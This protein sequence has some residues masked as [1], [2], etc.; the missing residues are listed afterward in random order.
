MNY[1][2]SH[3]TLYEFVC[4]SW[5]M[6][7]CFLG[8][9]HLMVSFTLIFFILRSPHIL[10]S[11]LEE[12]ILIVVMVRSMV[13]LKVIEGE[14]LIQLMVVGFIKKLALVLTVTVPLSF[15]IFLIFHHIF[16]RYLIK[17]L[18]DFDILF[19]FLVFCSFHSFI[20]NW[21]NSG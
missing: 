4:W 11:T 2:H 21:S 12:D 1:F 3:W 8:L 16:N 9:L 18:F 13:D 14:A 10:S 7:M 15:L 5:F 17:N 20:R 6:M 19:M